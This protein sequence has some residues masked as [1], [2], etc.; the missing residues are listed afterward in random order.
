MKLSQAEPVLLTSRL[1]RVIARAPRLCAGY[2]QFDLFQWLTLDAREAFSLAC[3]PRQVCGGSRIYSQSEP[4]NDMYRIVR[5]SVRMSVLRVDGR[6]AL[7]QV[8]QPGDCFGATSLLDGAPRCHTTNASGEV[9]LQVLRRDA[10]ERLRSQHPSFGEALIRLISR[11]MRLL[12][13]YLAS[14]TLDDLPS[15]VAQRLLKAVK[16]S[17]NG[18]NGICP[19]VH[20]SQSDLALMVGVSRQTVNKILKKFESEGLI[21]IEY[22]RVLIFDVDGLRAGR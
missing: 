17:V 10:Y 9:E 11:H 3:R 6:E 1:A 13:E 14:Y 21:G 22:G 5:G 18:A 8:L 20:L 2:S 4:G 16:S 19:T 12:S 7:Y 15:R